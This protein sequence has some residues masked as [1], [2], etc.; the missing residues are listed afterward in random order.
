MTNPGQPY[1]ES[2]RS[3]ARS[4]AQRSADDPAYA[5]QLQDDPVATLRSAGLA[6]DAIHDFMSEH[7]IE[8]EVSGYI[9]E[10]LDSSCYTTCLLTGSDLLGE[11]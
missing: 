7:G 9:L 11:V 1:S 2:V 4:I 8:K 6:D 5:Q 3:L 10:E